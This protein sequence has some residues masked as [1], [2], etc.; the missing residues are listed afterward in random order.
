MI[1]RI[2]II[3]MISDEGY[4]AANAIK[5]HL[6]NTW[7]NKHV[8]YNKITLMPVHSL[9]QYFIFDGSYDPEDIIKMTQNRAGRASGVGLKSFEC[10]YISSYIMA[11]SLI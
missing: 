1:N 11:L 2:A 10:L 9:I 5:K 3:G 8:M 4:Y 6:T 7:I